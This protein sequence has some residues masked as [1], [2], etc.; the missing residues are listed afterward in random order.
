MACE[1]CTERWRPWL[2]LLG[3]LAIVVVAELSYSNSFEVP[4]QFDDLQRIQGGAANHALWPP[5]KGLATSTR[6]VAAYTFAIDYA[7]HGSGVRGYHE[8]NLSIHVASAL[9]LLGVVRRSLSQGRLAPRYGPVAD[10]LALVVA[11]VW[12]AHPLQTEAVTYIYQR[13]E[14]LMGLFFLL[15]LYG[16]TRAQASP[17][18][19]LWYS[20]SVISSLLALGCKEVAAV[21]PLV[22]LWYDRAFVASTWSEVLRR[23]GS[24]YALLAG[25]PAL[26]AASLLMR[27]QIYVG[28]GALAVDGI[29]PLDYAL[30]QPGVILRYLRLC[31]W[32]QGQ[33][34]DYGWPLARSLWEIVPSAIVVAGLLAATLWATR[35]HRGWSFL[36]GAFF[37]ILAP[38]SSVVPIR[39]PA[40]EHRMYLPLAAVV[41]LAVL[42][43][44]E[45]FCGGLRAGR[46][47]RRS[48]RQTPCLPSAVKSS[49]CSAGRN[50][51]VVLMV[52]AMVSALGY[53]TYLRNRVYQSDLTLWRDVV[54][55]AP[56]NARGHNNYG[57]F[58][59]RAGRQQEGIACFKRAIEIDPSYGAAHHNL[60]TAERELQS[61]SDRRH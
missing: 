4:F 9:V 22:V 44:Y 40:V 61:R 1:V 16:F 34:L 49:R 26:L 20:S 57:T 5:W 52:A 15:T 39:D 33:C 25:V 2:R 19:V 53:T 42:V 50:A 3:V 10:R 24:Y 27:R 21:G 14:S 48:C 12:V 8:T 54:E 32:P 35:R 37:L 30:T 56:A 59:C 6:P 47:R 18:P 60:T 11:L 43:A 13:Y 41:T 38:T 17:R 45:V 55:K 36:G 46:S 58:L 29:S 7:L 23:R 31:V 51:A 28:G